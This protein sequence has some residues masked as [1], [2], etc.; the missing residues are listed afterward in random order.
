MNLFHK[1]L[2]LPKFS[3][4]SERFVKYRSLDHIIS[5]RDF[6]PLMPFYVI[7]AFLGIFAENAIWHLPNGIFSRKS[8]MKW[9]SQPNDRRNFPKFWECFRKFRELI[10]H[11][12]L[13]SMV[14]NFTTRYLATK[15]AGT[16]YQREWK[17]HSRV[18]I[19]AYIK[20]YRHI[21]Q[22]WK[23]VARVWNVLDQAPDSQSSPV[24]MELGW[25][26]QKNCMFLNYTWSG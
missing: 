1:G 3:K 23:V 22:C 18:R 17:H 16:F 8:Y 5:T 24:R 19:K 11:E 21:S 2:S 12:I 15:P 13:P 10:F 9:Y 7:L 4:N 14:I 20:A 25:T 6:L 26:G